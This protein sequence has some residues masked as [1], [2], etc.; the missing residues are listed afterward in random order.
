MLPSMEVIRETRIGKRIE[1]IA[2]REGEELGRREGEAEGR[3]RTLRLLMDKLFP[4]LVDIPDSALPTGENAVNA[5]LNLLLTEKDSAR[6]RRAL[7][8]EDRG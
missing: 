5:L 6:V 2:R 1:E 3:R 4:D 7:L 8:G